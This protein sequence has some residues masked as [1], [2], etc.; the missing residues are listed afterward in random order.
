MTR[1]MIC[2]R[3]PDDTELVV[4]VQVRND[5]PQ[6]LGY[7]AAHAARMMRDTVPFIYTGSGDDEVTAEHDGTEI[8]LS[9][10]GWV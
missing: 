7:A 2:Y 8:D 4:S 9:D 5:D 3:A 6:M 1:A 10:E